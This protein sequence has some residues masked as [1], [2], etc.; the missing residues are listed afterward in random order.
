M[1]TLIDHPSEQAE[2]TR[3]ISKKGLLAFLG[4]MLLLTFFSNTINNFLLPRVELE[5][6]ASG[7]L[8]KEVQASGNILPKMSQS[9]YTTLHTRVAAVYVKAGETVTQGQLIMTLDN[10]AVMADYQEA[11]LHLQKLKLSAEAD[12][13]NTGNHSL[14]RKRDE[15]KQKYENS[16]RDCERT[17]QLCQAGA[18]SALN[19]EKAENDMKTAARDYQQACEDYALGIKTSA[20]NISLQQLKVSQLKRQLD[21]DYALR[22]ACNGLVREVNCTPGS[23]TDSSKPLF[24]ITDPSQGYEFKMTIDSDSAVYLK[25]GDEFTVSLKAFKRSLPGRVARLTSAAEGKT[26]VF[27]DVTAD[28]LAG[29]ETGEAFIS[30][31]AGFYDYL[32]SNS[33]VQRDNSGAFVWLVR[34]R[35]GAFRNELYLQKLTVRVIDSDGSKTA[36]K[37]GALDQDQRIVRQVEGNPGLTEGCRVLISE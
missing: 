31:E 12:Q 35:H 21:F 37:G 4:V 34:E 29:G 24:V 7:A 33:A 27:L 16:R 26:D 6:P 25:K 20:C 14:A 10:T 5:C 8:I 15:A 32:V 2:K 3:A 11:V 13:A 30:K 28:G 1:N 36:L 18:E 23:L 19:L 17:R 9:E 22:A